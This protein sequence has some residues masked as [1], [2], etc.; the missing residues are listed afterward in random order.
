[1]TN[2]VNFTAN[3]LGLFNMLSNKPRV[4][5]QECCIELQLK[6]WPECGN[7]KN[8]TLDIQLEYKC[9]YFSHNVFMLKKN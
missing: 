8:L 9:N 3:K 4:E 2:I 1:M 5:N 6:T 7:Q